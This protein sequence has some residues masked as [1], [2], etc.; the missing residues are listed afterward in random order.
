MVCLEYLI[1]SYQNWYLDLVLCDWLICDPCELCDIHFYFTKIVVST[2]WAG[3][4]CKGLVSS[5]YFSLPDQSAQ[6]WRSHT[7]CRYSF[8]HCHFVRLWLVRGPVSDNKVWYWSRHALQ[9]LVPDVV[10]NTSKLDGGI[11]DIVMHWPSTVGLEL[12]LAAW[13]LSAG[14]LVSVPICQGQIRHTS[15]WGTYKQ[16]WSV[17]AVRCWSPYR[18]ITPNH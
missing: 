10:Y 1:L 9:L 6:I 5:L 2:N 4:F 7:W 12:W 15:Q 18:R 13:K 17:M 14:F 16:S 8:W 3:L 11:Y